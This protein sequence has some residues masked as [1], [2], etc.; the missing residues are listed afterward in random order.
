[1][2][3]W[4]RTTGTRSS[5][6]FSSYSSAAAAAAAAASPTM[7]EAYIS[8]SAGRPPF[9]VDGIDITIP[10]DY[11]KGKCVEPRTSKTSAWWN[12][13]HEG[14]DRKDPYKDVACCNLCGDAISLTGGGTRSISRHIFSCNKDVWQVL[15]DVQIQNADKKEALEG[16]PGDKKSIN[17]NR[18]RLKREAEH[19]AFQQEIDNTPPTELEGLNRLIAVTKELV[20]AKDE[21]IAKSEELVKAKDYIIKKSEELVKAKDDIIDMKSEKIAELQLELSNLHGQSTTV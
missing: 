7:S 21:T 17:S 16:T 18:K 15:N 2:T 1:L 12:A 3:P 14:K 11:W 4:R 6:W 19:A 9:I 20:K 5:P 10:H 13:Y 8:S